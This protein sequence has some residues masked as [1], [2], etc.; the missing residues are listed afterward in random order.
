MNSGPMFTCFVA[1]VA[2]FIHIAIVPIRGVLYGNGICPPIL[3][4]FIIF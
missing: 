1:G 2:N 3:S 4:C